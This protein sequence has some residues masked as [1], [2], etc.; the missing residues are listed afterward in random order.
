MSIIDVAGGMTLEQFNAS[1]A[2]SWPEPKGGHVVTWTRQLADFINRSP[3]AARSFLSEQHVLW[4]QPRLLTL[5]QLYDRIFQYYHRRQCSHCHS[6]PRE[7]SICLV[8]GALV[9]LKENCCKQL[10]ICEAVQHS[11]DCGAGTAMYLVVTSSYVIV[12]RGKR[13]CLWGSVYLDSF[14]EEDRE[15]KSVPFL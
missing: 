6:V 8:C 3:V 11:V 10:N 14:G 1:V 5:P 13:A 12:I 7:T 9:C 2:L 4:H 15:L